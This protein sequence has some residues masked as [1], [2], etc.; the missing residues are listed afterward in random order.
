MRKW[1][2]ELNRDLSKEEVQMATKHMKKCWTSHSVK[3]ATMKNTATTNVGEVFWG[4]KP[5]YTAGRNVN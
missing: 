3:I 1:A 4:K 2:N 5:S